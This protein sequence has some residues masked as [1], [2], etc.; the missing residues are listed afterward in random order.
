LLGERTHL[1]PSERQLFRQV[2]SGQFL[3]R[4]AERMT[5]MNQTDAAAPRWRRFRSVSV[6]GLIFLIIVIAGALGWI[7]NRAATQRQAVAAI[8]QVGGRVWYDW[9]WR[10]GSPL[11]DAS[12]H[13]PV[14]LVNSLGSDYFGN[15]VAVSLG[16]RT[17]DRELSHLARL[18]HLEHLDLHGSSV[19][20]N[21]LANLKGL[22]RLR[23][24][25]LVRNKKL[26]DFSLVH[27]KE[28]RDL[29][30]LSLDHTPIGD[31]GLEHLK[32][33]ANL[34]ELNL[35]G[36]EISDGGLV[37]I[38]GLAN[39]TQLDLT[40]TKI[41]DGGMAHLKVLDKLQVLS[42]TRTNVSDAGLV[43]LSGLT[44][45]Q[46]LDLDRDR[47]GD[48]GLVHLAALTRLERLWLKATAV[49]DAGLV[50]L[51]G[52]TALQELTLDGTAVTDKG[53]PQLADLNGLLILTLSR[54]KVSQAG[55]QSL[56]MAIPKLAID[57]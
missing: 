38:G 21:G 26:G 52:L 50:H 56:Q 13:W 40:A 46:E 10:D 5:A 24:L 14:W 28:L 11:F 34:E 33:L 22:F 45:L 43:Y 9:E 35:G 39:L 44:N 23:T 30:V 12:P 15:V 4:R 31:P 27:L 8:Q 37:A 19:T 47:I 1:S 20:A 55:L 51:K 16:G 17:T 29:R 42:L 2:I 3:S 7:S 49:T 54:T 6:R 25:L 32:H 48:A 57:Y 53:L 36:T 41:G 18:A